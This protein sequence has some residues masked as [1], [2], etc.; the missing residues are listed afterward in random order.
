MLAQHIFPCC[1]VTYPVSDLPSDP[2]LEFSLWKSMVA[3]TKV[4]EVV[5]IW[6]GYVRENVD[7]SND[8]KRLENLRLG[9][10]ERE[11]VMDDLNLREA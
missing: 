4:M 3:Q 11:I 5:A 2:T 7:A 8:S 10:E 6:Q 1:S 9:L